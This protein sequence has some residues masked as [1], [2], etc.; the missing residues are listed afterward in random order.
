MVHPLKPFGMASVGCYSSQLLSLGECLQCRLPWGHTIQ[1]ETTLRHFHQ[2]LQQQQQWYAYQQQ[3]QQWVQQQQLEQQVQ[4]MQRQQLQQQMQQQM[5]Q[6]HEQLQQQQQQRQRQRQRQPQQPQQPQPLRTCPPLLAEFLIT[7]F[8]EPPNSRSVIFREYRQPWRTAEDDVPDERLPVPRP[9]RC[10]ADPEATH[11]PTSPLP[12]SQLLSGDSES[13]D[14]NPGDPA[15]DPPGEPTPDLPSDPA[16]DPPG[17][18]APEPGPEPSYPHYSEVIRT[19][20]VT[21]DGGSPWVHRPAG[22][23]GHATVT[24]P[25]D[26]KRRRAGEQV[27]PDPKFS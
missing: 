14:P 5:Q 2:Q 11:L 27:A 7:P 12:L 13:R 8:L 26:E 1:Q 9:T 16:S 10:P 20:F 23:R 15:P 19:L 3:Q 4:Q 24:L 25:W 6:H 21:H 17:D 18:P 22:A